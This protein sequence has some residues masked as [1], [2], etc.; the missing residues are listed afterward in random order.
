[1]NE[2]RFLRRMPHMICTLLRKCVSV[3]ESRYEEVFYAWHCELFYCIVLRTAETT[4]DVLKMYVY[5]IQPV[6]L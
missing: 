3:F 4:W 6:D 1:M 5:L 2:L